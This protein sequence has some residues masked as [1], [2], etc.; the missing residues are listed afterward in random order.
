MPTNIFGSAPLIRPKS[1]YLRDTGTILENDDNSPVLMTKK[2]KKKSGKE[3]IEE[4]GES[5]DSPIIRKP[6]AKKKPIA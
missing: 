4:E 6:V 2:L 3:L 1:C 5:D